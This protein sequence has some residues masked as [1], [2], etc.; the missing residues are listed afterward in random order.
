MQ[1]DMGY[2]V[3]KNSTDRQ[4]YTSDLSW[5]FSR[6]LTL[7]F[8]YDWS[9]QETDIITKIQTFTTDLSARF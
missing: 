2:T 5:N 1:L 7:R 6:A 9:R 3:D 4:T 8:G